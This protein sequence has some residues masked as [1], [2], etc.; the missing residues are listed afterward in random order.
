V[1]DAN[2]KYLDTANILEILWVRSM[3]LLRVVT[4]L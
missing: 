3:A 4:W 2:G 1:E